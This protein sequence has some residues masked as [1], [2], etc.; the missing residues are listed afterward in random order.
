V[1]STGVGRVRVSCADAPCEGRLAVKVGRR[2][3]GLGS[4]ELAQGRSGKVAFKLNRRGRALLRSARALRVSLV[5]V[6]DGRTVGRRT[7]RLTRR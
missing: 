7:V 1:S 2:T 4:F 5:A 6:S 3:I